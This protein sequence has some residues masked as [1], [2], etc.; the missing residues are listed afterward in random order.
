MSEH[1]THTRRRFITGAGLTA[2]GLTMPEAVLV[3]CSGSGSSNSGSGGPSTSLSLWIDITGTANQAYFQ[4]HVMQAFEKANPKIDI[5]ATY[6]AGADLRRLITTALAAKSGP[7][8]VR[9]LSAS[10][11]LAWSDSHLLDTLNS[12]APAGGW[13]SNIAGWALKP[14][15]LKGKI[16]ALPLRTDT[17]MMYYNK[18]LFEQKN[19][20][21]PKNR[22]ELEALAK[23]AQGHGLIPLGGTNSTYGASTEWL[24]TFFWNHFAGPNALYQALT[25]KI[26]WTEAVFVDAIELM[27][28]Y[29]KK[30]WV[31]G[32]T[33]KYYAVPQN[34]ISAQFGAGQV[35]L[36]PNGE[37]MM[38]TLS[39]FFG[40][41]AS[42]DNEWD[43]APL[44]AL[45][46]GIPYP[47][48]EVGVGGSLGINA[49]TKHRDQAAKFLQW[50]Y[51]DK[52]QA[53][54]R[55]AAIPGT[56][57]IPI[58][59]T[60]SELPKTMDPRSARLLT[61]VEDALTT[62]HFGYVTWTW[63]SPKADTFVYQGADM[64]LTGKLSPKEYCSQLNTTF[65]KELKV[66]AVP[67]TL[68]P[69]PQ[70]A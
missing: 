21:P 58:P 44:P 16:Y 34:T 52:Q 32:S 48:F 69:G 11:D 61:S 43:W 41:A 67:P 29:F 45:N 30:G 66:G 31:A 6:Y 28:N 54:S 12:F 62:G 17:M 18:S 38:P 5:N 33:Q 50:Y 35:A 4:G 10:Q 36:Y 51:G 2:L 65:R 20:K 23:E 56:Y 22:D 63:W 24:V 40:K 7:D 19:W 27:A 3:A 37:W 53:L 42:N 70:P 47:L 59:Y 68:A 8:I 13:S 49:A 55:M 60:K 46:S 64:V 26:P 15:T 57:N 39:Q 1:S 9:G 14:F 25:G